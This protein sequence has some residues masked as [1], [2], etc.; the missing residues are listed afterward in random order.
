MMQS[1][2]KTLDKINIEPRPVLNDIT[3]VIPTLGR[4]ILAESLYWIAANSAWPADLIVVDQGANPEVAVWLKMLRSIGLRTQHI[5]SSQ[6]GKAAA[7]NCGIKCV[8]TRFIV[9]TDDD[10]FVGVDWLKNMATH[11]RQAPD[12]I[13]TG[14]AEPEGDEV[15]VAA[16]TSHTKAIYRRPR[17]KFDTFC[18]SNMGVA[19]TA[20]KQIGLFDEDPVL[21]AA[22]DCEWSYRALRTGVPII[23]VPEIAVR[24][25]S[26]RDKSK[27]VVRYK[28]YAQSHGGFYGKYLRKGDWFI[29]LRIIIHHLRALRRWLYGL[30]T[31]NQDSALYGRAYLMG[32]LPGIIAGLRQGRKL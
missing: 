28:N 5:P 12:A 25:Y 24:H 1:P 17:L 4:P 15:T 2:L 22:E 13:I 6:R 3:V 30:I 29:G 9:V 11:L 8:T 7:L 21:V 23:Y 16:V 26:W 14:P 31:G 18:G 27:R 19:I 20:I 32:L 10:C